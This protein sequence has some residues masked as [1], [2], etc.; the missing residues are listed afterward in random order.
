[1]G[2]ML[3]SQLSGLV[4]GLNSTKKQGNLEN[5]H[6]RVIP[7]KERGTWGIY[8]PIQESHKRRAAREGCKCPASYGLKAA[9]TSEPFGG[10]KSARA[11]R[12]DTSETLTVSVTRSNDPRPIC[13]SHWF[14]D[15][16]MTK[17]YL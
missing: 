14:R 2:G 11:P 1:M 10:W 16:T 17:N 7:C 4:V 15:F 6:F 8:T 5:I 9:G 13:S 12:K 3:G